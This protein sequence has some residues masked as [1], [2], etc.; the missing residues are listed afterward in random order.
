MIDFNFIIIIIII[1]YY[2]YFIKLKARF[3]TI[4]TV[5]N[6][7]IPNNI[8]KITPKTV[9]IYKPNLIIGFI[10]IKNI[11]LNN[12]KLSIIVYFNSP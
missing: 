7:I 10:S 1:I 2:L 8:V 6:E 9:N 3:Q 11:F 4:N 5:K 12:E